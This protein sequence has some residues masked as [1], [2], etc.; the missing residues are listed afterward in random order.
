MLISICLFCLFL[1]SGQS[2]KTH[3][4]PFLVDLVDI[5]LS[6]RPSAIHIL[7]VLVQFTDYENHFKIIDNI[8][9]KFNQPDA[10]QGDVLSLM[11]SAVGAV[12]YEYLASIKN[13]HR[14]ML[15]RLDKFKRL[16]VETVPDYTVVTTTGPISKPLG[17]V[18]LEIVHLFYALLQAN[19]PEID[20]AFAEHRILEVLIELFFEY[21]YNSF[22]HNHVNNIVAV[23]FLNANDSRFKLSSN[24]AERTDF[25]AINTLAKWLE[26]GL[27]YRQVFNI[28]WSDRECLQNAKRLMEEMDESAEVNDE[29]KEQISAEISQLIHES[30]LNYQTTP[31]KTKYSSLISQVFSECS[32]L[33]RLMEKFQ[34]ILRERSASSITKPVPTHKGNLI[35]IAKIINRFLVE[36]EGDTLPAELLENASFTAVREAWQ[37]FSANELVLVDNKIIETEQSIKN[38]QTA[39]QDFRRYLM[40]AKIKPL[41]IGVPFLP[42]D[43]EFSLSPFE[44]HLDNE[45]R[46]NLWNDRLVLRPNFCDGLEE[47][48]NFRKRNIETADDFKGIVIKDRQFDEKPFDGVDLAETLQ[49]KLD[50]TKET[51]EGEQISSL[52]EKDH[53]FEPL[54]SSSNISNEL[55]IEMD[56][57]YFR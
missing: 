49:S 44:T 27:S 8:K 35:D 34:S 14:V 10:N 4:E 12:A 32:L 24:E 30:L 51:E 55:N 25:L 54:A 9:S 22:L 36:F 6:H 33:E 19:N 41:D 1:T 43:Y 17:F 26:K 20:E 23:I 38:Q 40:Q 7:R 28:V 42:N 56:C 50:S 31:C 2:S 45:M 37:A 57:E 11:G 48:I 13:L 5:C 47:E 21:E 3:S 29:I 15:S 52:N 18:R 53:L 46:P 16:L 39:E